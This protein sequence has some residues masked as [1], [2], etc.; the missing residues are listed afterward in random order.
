M[1]PEQAAG[2]VLWDEP[3]TDETWLQPDDPAMFGQGR[4]W[5]RVEINWLH[6]IKIASEE[7]VGPSEE[8]VAASEEG[9]APSEEGVAPTE[10]NAAPGPD[11][12]KGDFANP[13]LGSKSRYAYEIWNA[14]LSIFPDGIPENYSDPRLKATLEPKLREAKGLELTIT[15]SRTTDDAGLPGQFARA[16]QP[17]WRH[18]GSRFWRPLSVV[19]TSQPTAERH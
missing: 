4:Y 5:K 13:H 8:G 16:R 19:P 9:V 11:K 2:L 18:A 6:V 14:A 17:T 12:Q 3:S 1:P 7:G 10:M 15:G